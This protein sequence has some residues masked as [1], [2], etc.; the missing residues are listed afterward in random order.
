[1][2]S[3]ALLQT[4]RGIFSLEW[5]LPVDGAKSSTCDASLNEGAK[6]ML[7]CPGAGGIKAITFAEYGTPSGD[8]QHGFKAGK[9]GVD[10]AGNLTKLCVGKA[11]CTVSCSGP[12]CTI[13]GKQLETGDPCYQTKKKLSAQVSCGGSKPDP[14]KKPPVTLAVKTTVPHTAL[15]GNTARR[16]PTRSTPLCSLS[17]SLS[18]SLLALYPSFF[19]G[20]SL[21]RV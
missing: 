17:L 8:C 10:L 6:I 13:D 7:G 1:M 21:A 5:H 15:G 18:L 14:S 12:A 2:F 16:L 20:V 4:M 11:S 3:P 9:C 19:P